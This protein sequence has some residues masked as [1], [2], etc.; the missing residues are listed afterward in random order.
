[1]VKIG[2]FWSGSRITTFV[3]LFFLYL[4]TVFNVHI[5]II[6]YVYCTLSCTL[7]ET[8]GLRHSLQ[9]VYSHSLQ[10]SKSAME[11]TREN[12]IQLIH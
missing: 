7:N 10:N 5:C 2:G 1:M 9:I 4:H 12:R 3:F 8:K 6:L 11:T